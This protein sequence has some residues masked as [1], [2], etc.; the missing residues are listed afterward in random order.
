MKNA[1][2]AATAA[3]ALAV[4]VAFAARNPV[5]DAEGVSSANYI[6][7][8]YPADI[9]SDSHYIDARPNVDAASGDRKTRVI[10]T[11]KPLGTVIMLI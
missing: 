10:D 4:T 7:A 11:A 3:T 5:G 2:L 8:R 1:K 6:D 9:G